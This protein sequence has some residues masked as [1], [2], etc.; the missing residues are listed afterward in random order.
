MTSTF[1]EIG[2]WTYCSGIVILF[3]GVPWYFA[4]ALMIVGIVFWDIDEYA[5][6]KR[7]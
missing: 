7:E 3:F 5:Q 1:S 4:V 6:S 2:K